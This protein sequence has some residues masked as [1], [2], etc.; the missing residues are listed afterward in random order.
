VSALAAR[1]GLLRIP[2]AGAAAL[3]LGWILFVGY[4]LARGSVLAACLLAAAPLAGLGVA[5][6]VESSGTILFFAAFGLTLTVPAL[7]G[8]LGGGSVAV[9]AADLVVV[10]AVAAWLPS[11]LVGGL[12][13]TR[14]RPLRTPVLGLPLLV[15]GVLTFWAA[16]RGHE[17]YGASLVGQPLRLF[18]YAAIAVVVIQMDVRR[19][20]AGL[21]AV[22]YAGAVWEA[23]VGVYYMVTGGS[24][25]T[26]AELSTGGTRLLAL[27][28]SLYVAAAVFLALLNI[29]Y[30]ES[31]RR[32]PLH[33][34]IAL[35]ATFD[36]LIA[37]GR[38]TYVAVAVF[39]LAIVLAFREIRRTIVRLIP[40]LLPLGV[41]AFLL[42]PESVR[43]LG[44]T[45]VS[46]L[47]S[48]L[49]SDASVQWREL[50]N[51]SILRQFHD[52]P[53]TGV[54]FGKGAHFV[55]NGVEYEITQD[56]HNSFVF[57][58]AGGGLL[59]LGAFLA[60]LA[61]Y[62]L[63]TWRRFRSAD[64]PYERVIVIWAAVTLATFVGNALAEPL[65]TYPSILLTIWALLVLPSIVP[66]REP[67]APV[68]PSN[69]GHAPS[70]AKAL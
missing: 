63:D 27:D 38:G 28:V 25:S 54:G 37:F 32:R 50:A 47:D 3:A 34:L 45:F 52:S 40:L 18:A 1:A 53:L 6:L 57:L 19:A 70:G 9:F 41:L 68:D 30:D 7:N 46:R 14:P 15:F 42:L 58:L 24:Q 29:H 26:A 4:A 67:A 66:K 17:E 35:V 5:R 23:L 8:P 22:F 48:R 31:R 59:L 49:G 69:E 12:P 39:A 33:V 21:S 55:L 2:L 20:W 10:A 62:A 16:L 36:V 13:L 64:T 60:I 65:F 11:R 51:E 56:P 61:V 43:G 44:P